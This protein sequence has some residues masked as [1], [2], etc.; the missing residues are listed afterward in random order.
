MESYVEVGFD[1]VGGRFESRSI[2]IRWH[3]SGCRGNRENPLLPVPRAL[4]GFSG[5]WIGQKGLGTLLRQF[6]RGSLGP[7]AVSF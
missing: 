6:G 3:R 4:P 7:A 1:V 2:R 5:G